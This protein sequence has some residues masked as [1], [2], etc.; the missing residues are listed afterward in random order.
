MITS[1][2]AT[3]IHA[4]SPL[5]ATGVDAAAA[6]AEAAD[7]ASAA[8]GAASCANAEPLRPTKPRAAR[9]R[10][11]EAMIFRMGCLLLEIFGGGSER[12]FAGFT[13]ADAHDLL[14]RGDEDLAVTDLAG[15][16]S[17]FDRFD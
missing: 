16:C 9:P 5:L 13:G 2:V 7:A 12:V 14:E 1:S 10:A 11:R 4:T 17:A 6:G 8:A 15:A 3:I